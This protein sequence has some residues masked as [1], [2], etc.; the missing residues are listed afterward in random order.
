M[1]DL[2]HLPHHDCSSCPK[3]EGLRRCEQTWTRKWTPGED[4]NTVEFVL[5]ITCILH[6]NYPSVG[7]AIFKENGVVVQSPSGLR[8]GDGRLQPFAGRC[9]RGDGKIIWLNEQSDSQ[10]AEYPINSA[11]TQRKS[12]ANQLLC[13]TSRG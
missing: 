6:I 2:T 11:I 8:K 4:D 1:H 13:V 10:W 12:C 3:R 9:T 5:N 7:V